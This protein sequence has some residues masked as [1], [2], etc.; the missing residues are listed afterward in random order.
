MASDVQQKKP[1]PDLNP[2]VY[3]MWISI[4]I[5]LLILAIGEVIAYFIYEQVNDNT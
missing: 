5:I 3:Y 2:A 1:E 4:Y